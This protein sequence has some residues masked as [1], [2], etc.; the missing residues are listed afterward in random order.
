MTCVAVCHEQVN[1]PTWTSLS[2]QLEIVSFITAL[3]LGLGSAVGLWTLDIP[4]ALIVLVAVYGVLRD[5]RALLRLPA[6][7]ESTASPT[8]VNRSLRDRLARSFP[9]RK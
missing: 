9:P 7:N 8:S 2:G 1:G 3:S 5:V 6:R 4:M